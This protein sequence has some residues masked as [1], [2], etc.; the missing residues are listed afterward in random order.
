MFRDRENECP[1]CD[2]TGFL[3][4]EKDAFFYYGPD[5]IRQANRSKDPEWRKKMIDRAISLKG[6]PMQPMAVT[7]PKCK[8]TGLKETA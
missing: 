8:G 7:C 3:L 5:L 2:G 1:F 6:V 4:V